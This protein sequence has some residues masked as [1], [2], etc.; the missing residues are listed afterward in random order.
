MIGRYA[1]INR[2]RL[3]TL[4]LDRALKTVLPRGPFGGQ[5]RTFSWRWVGGYQRSF[6]GALTIRFLGANPAGIY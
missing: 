2:D 4:L 3:G 1:V 5:A 6:R